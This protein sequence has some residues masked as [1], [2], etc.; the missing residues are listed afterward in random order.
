MNKRPGYMLMAG[1]LLL[2]GALLLVIGLLAVGFLR[3]R[4]E[5][6]RQETQPPVVQIIEPQVGMSAMI[7]SSLPVIANI[8]DSADAPLQRVEVWLDG[9]VQEERE[10]PA[11]EGDLAPILYAHFQMSSEGVHLLTVRAVNRL[12]IVGQSE[13]RLIV[14]VPKQEEAHLLVTLPEGGS[15]AS[16]AAAYNT[17]EATLQALN[18]SLASQAPAPG[19]IISVPKPAENEPPPAAH[20]AVPPPANFQPINPAVLPLDPAGLPAWNLTLLTVLPPAAP[21]GLL[22]QVK[23]C[24]V[25]LAWNDN[26]DNEDGF[27]VWMAGTN[28]PAHIL[29]TLQP[30]PGGQT[31]FE[32]PAPAGGGL[33]FWVEA[34][35]TIGSQ[36]SNIVLAEVDSKCAPA[37]ATQL[38]IDLQD[39]S[40]SGNYER[41][42]CYVSLEGAPETRLPEQDGNFI[43][44]QGGQGKLAAWP[45]VFSVPLPADNS[46]EVSGECWGWA[47][48]T[49]AKLGNFSGVFPIQTWNGGRLVLDGGAFQFG[50]AISPLGAVNPGGAQVY[51]YFPDPLLPSPYDVLEE[52]TRCPGFNCAGTF[53]SWKWKPSPAFKQPISGFEIYLDGNAY[54][55]VSDPTA[56]SIPVSPPTGCGKSVR[57]QVAAVAGTVRS[58]LSLP[59][60]YDLPACQAYVVVKFETLE[61]PWTGDGISD[62]PCDELQLYYEL[63]LSSGYGNAFKEF[64]WG[65]SESGL[66]PVVAAFFPT[67]ALFTLGSGSIM[68]L[69]SIRCT[70]DAPPYTFAAMGS[71]FGVQN[72]DT[73]INSIPQSNISIEVGTF[74]Y[75]QDSDSA[76]DHFGF[77]ILKHNYPDLQAAQTDLG[78]GKTFRDPPTGY[79]IEDTADTAV[80][81]TLTVYPNPCGVVPQGIPL[82]THP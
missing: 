66:D 50:M 43:Q 81:Y 5:Q 7:D 21:S 30:S 70:K 47:G 27:E 31:W 49:L 44:V 38:Q 57:W 75:D 69:L 1:L 32:F 19:A 51:D 72:P 74:F 34:Y 18:P 14:G 15:L 68:E 55:T 6:A 40:V 20:P 60:D 4:Q 16:V 23:D 2:A 77:R 37:A 13:P 36:P 64:G 82:P 22:A 56:R 8:Y 48:S 71:A 73:L 29:A 78:C 80:S 46:V 17:D 25:T 76:N 35:N 33:S 24:R 67:N 79:R 59:F 10:Y 63:G 58:M 12:G 53:L 3:H 39:L 54:K 11:A 45:H 26:S 28:S 62:G 61:I 65:G 9:E 52:G 41:A 42:Y